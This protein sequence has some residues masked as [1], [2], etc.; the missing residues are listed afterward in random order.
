MPYY[1]QDTQE[2]ARTYSDY[3]KTVHWKNVKEEFTS[4]TGGVCQLCRH[5]NREIQLHHVSYENV[6]RETHKDIQVI[7][8]DCHARIHARKPP[9]PQPKTVA[10]RPEDYIHAS[11]GMQRASV[12]VPFCRMRKT[13]STCSFREF[14]FAGHEKEI[15]CPACREYYAAHKISRFPLMILKT[16]PVL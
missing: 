8:S 1:C 5:P 7:C 16:K 13:G 15:T 11:I 3:L 2:T 12:L 14:R 6:G 10:T 4:A 9:Q